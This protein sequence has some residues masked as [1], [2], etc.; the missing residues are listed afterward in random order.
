MQ[1]G[2]SI[3]VDDRLEKNDVGTVVVGGRRMTVSRIHGHDGTPTVDRKNGKDNGAF[4]HV[5]TSEGKDCHDV[6][7]VMTPPPHTSPLP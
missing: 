1:Y 7:F 2:G 3:D 6:F 5:L 4:V